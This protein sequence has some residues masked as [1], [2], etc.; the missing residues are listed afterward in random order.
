MPEKETEVGAHL[1]PEWIAEYALDK[2]FKLYFDENYREAKVF[3][4]ITDAILMDIDPSD[5]LKARL[6]LKYLLTWTMTYQA[7]GAFDTPDLILD[8]FSKF[9]EYFERCDEFLEAEVPRNSSSQWW[10]LCRSIKIQGAIKYLKSIPVFKQDNIDAL[11]AYERKCFR[12]FF[13]KKSQISGESSEEIKNK[14]KDE[15]IVIDMINEIISSPEFTK[16]KS[17]SSAI[18]KIQKSIVDTSRLVASNPY[19]IF[20]KKCCFY[21]KNIYTRALNKAFLFKEA[22]NYLKNESLQQ[23]NPQSPLKSSEI[24]ENS[25]STGQATPLLENFPSSMLKSVFLKSN[26]SAHNLKIWDDSVVKGKIPESAPT[27]VKTPGKQNASKS[28]ARPSIQKSPEKQPPPKSPAK[29]IA[30]KSPEK[31]LAPKS[32]EKQV[33]PKSPQKQPVQKSPAK[34]APT[35]SPKKA[36]PS[37][38]SPSTTKHAI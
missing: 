18:R 11:F 36:I 33:A 34:V 4:D 27:P 12:Y 38:S 25:S 6:T 1:I 20:K 22:E 29:Q 21:L 17:N 8:A 23:D 7:D 2:S 19:D 26:P 9:L 37:Q 3:E 14:T 28:P 24:K 5:N 31:Q 13:E 32:P 30:P 16:Q 15:K 35:S 10:Q